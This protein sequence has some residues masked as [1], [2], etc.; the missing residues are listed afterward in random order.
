MSGAEV[1]LTRDAYER[2]RIELAELVRQ[3]TGAPLP[4][5]AHPRDSTDP[6][7]DPAALGERRD[8]E[9]RIRRLQRVLRQARVGTPADDGVAEPGMLLTIR[10]GDDPDTETFLLA[11]RDD[12]AALDLETCSP[13]S[14]LGR[15]LLGAREGEQRHCALPG[16]REIRVVLLRAVPYR[17]PRP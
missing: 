6:A 2:L 10:Y 15:A 16:G 5:G 4:V 11:H 7:T 14:P 9:A 1:W 13:D 17:D 12:A 8:R 3:R